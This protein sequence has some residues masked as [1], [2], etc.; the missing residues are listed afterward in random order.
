VLRWQG[1]CYLKM[2]TMKNMDFWI[3]GA[4]FMRKYYSIF[5]MDQ[6]RV[7]LVGLSYNTPVD[8][9]LVMII[10]YSGTALMVGVMAAVLWI[11]CRNKS[12]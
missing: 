5:D 11:T 8:M 10:T 6:K 4:T 12:V 9:T 1:R 3:L 7:G 2:Q